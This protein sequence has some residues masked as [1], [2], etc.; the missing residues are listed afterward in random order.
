MSLAVC[1]TGSVA[2]L[3]RFLGRWEALARVLQDAQCQ[4][5]DRGT[6]VGGL[7][8]GAELLR[9]TS[10]CV[11]KPSRTLSPDAC[12]G[13]SGRG[14]RKPGAVMSSW[15]VLGI[16]AARFRVP[17][18]GHP[19]GPGLALGL[20]RR[21]SGEV[22][23]GSDQVAVLALLTKTLQFF[24]VQTFFCRVDKRRLLPQLFLA[25]TQAGFGHRWFSL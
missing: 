19:L 23:Q 5:Q 24:L 21:D 12:R 20:G 16:F 8:Q 17:C 22:R 2:W 18:T 14:T 4:K 9:V 11:A 7:L 3:Q 13:A 6:A 10:A 1:P 15:D 25:H